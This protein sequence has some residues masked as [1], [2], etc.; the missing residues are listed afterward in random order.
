[1][2]RADFCLCVLYVQME[3]PCFCLYCYKCTKHQFIHLLTATCNKWHIENSKNHF[4]VTWRHQNVTIELGICLFLLVV[5]WNHASILHRYGDI[6]PQR[7]W[8]HDFDLLWSRDVI[9]HVTVG[10]G[11][12]GF[13]LVV[14]WNHAS[15]F[16]RYGDI[17]LK[18]AFAHVKGL[19]FT[20]H[21][22]CHL[23]CRQGSKMTTYLAFPSPH[24]LF[25]IQ[26][27][28]GYDDD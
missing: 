4:G 10:L 23:T 28:W 26:L 25:T 2:L 5:H 7:Y 9:G 8:G 24:C 18:V 11:I 14:H 6:G 22:P 19:K 20:A 1:L 17:S 21:A 15:I 27:L 16:H 13:L 3:I 12:C